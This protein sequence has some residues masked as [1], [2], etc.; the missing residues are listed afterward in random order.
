VFFFAGFRECNADHSVVPDRYYVA[1][2]NLVTTEG[3]IKAVWFHDALARIVDDETY[4]A[5]TALR[6]LAEDVRRLPAE[7]ARLILTRAAE[8]RTEAAF[9]II[10][11]TAAQELQPATK[12]WAP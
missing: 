6:S 10:C 2:F 12:V 5:V 8:A 1:V 11:K 9:T 4:F 3:E 7:E